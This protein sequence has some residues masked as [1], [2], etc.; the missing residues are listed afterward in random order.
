MPFISCSVLR[1]RNL[2]A[3]APKK[4]VALQ[5]RRRPSV[6]A[7][8]ISSGSDVGVIA[9]S[10]G[11][12]LPAMAHVPSVGQADTGAERM[13]LEVAEQPAREVILLPMLGRTELPLV[14]VAPTAAGMVPL[15]EVPPM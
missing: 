10:A 15:V 12:A 1:R 7:A 8:P 3:L 11:Q 14:L 13:P 9:S 4:S 2:F 6:D 5:V